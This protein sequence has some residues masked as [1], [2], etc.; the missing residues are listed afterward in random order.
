DQASGRGCRHRRASVSS[1]HAQGERMP[2]PLKRQL[3]RAGAG[4]ELVSRLAARRFL[5]RRPPPT[6]HEPLR[7][8]RVAE[9]AGAIFSTLLS[10]VL[11]VAIVALL[12]ALA[13]EYRRDAFTLDGFS[14]PKDL[15]DDGFTS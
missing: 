10:I 7:V 15:V 12:A 9:Y 14:A 3:V 13:R 4:V 1:G 2:N 11:V 8:T 5:L 6:P